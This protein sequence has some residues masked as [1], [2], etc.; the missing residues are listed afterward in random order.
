M[1]L[2]THTLIAA[3]KTALFAFRDKMGD[4]VTALRIETLALV[5]MEPGIEQKEAGRPLGVS[6]TAARRNI[7]DLGKR[8]EDGTPGPDFV[9]QREFPLPGRGAAR[10]V[11]YPTAKGLHWL[12]GL[13]GEVATVTGVP[14]DVA[15]L[16]LLLRMGMSLMREATDSKI[17]VYRMLILLCTLEQPGLGHTALGEAAGIHVPAAIS[18]NIL[19]LTAYRTD[20]T[21]GPD[22]LEQRLDPLYRKEQR[23]YTTPKAQCWL[24]TVVQ[25]INAKLLKSKG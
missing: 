15:D 8:K 22:L 14:V 9:E 2:T 11:A 10:K 19:N 3:L 21:P 25:Q 17:A 4:E 24:E 6:V 12:E 1:P 7:V 5:V 23:I 16:V 20:R 13:A 18:R